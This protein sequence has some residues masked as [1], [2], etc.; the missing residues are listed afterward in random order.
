[1]IVSIIGAL[2]AAMAAVLLVPVAVFTLQV[3]AARRD[4]APATDRL[5]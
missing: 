3:A 5:A 1:M 2:L 4:A